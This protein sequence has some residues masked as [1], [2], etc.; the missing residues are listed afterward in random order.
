MAGGESVRSFKTLLAWQVQIR[1]KM[2]NPQLGKRE[3]RGRRLCVT[4]MVGWH[5]WLERGRKL[6]EAKKGEGK[7]EMTQQCR[8]ILTMLATAIFSQIFTQS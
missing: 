6:M 8:C 1:N 5:H 4:A 3:E 2:K 7:M